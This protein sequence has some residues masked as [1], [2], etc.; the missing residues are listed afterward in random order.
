[1][2]HRAVQTA[3]HQSEEGGEGAGAYSRREVHQATGMVLAQ[4]HITPAEAL[5]V[6]RGHAFASGRTVLEV[7]ADVIDRRLDFST[8]D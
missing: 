6:L 2:L 4:M 7:A 1:V 5:L 3:T 8:E